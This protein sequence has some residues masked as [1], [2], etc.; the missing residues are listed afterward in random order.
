[1]DTQNA[2]VRYSLVARWS[3]EVLG[4]L[5]QKLRRNK[6]NLE[7]ILTPTKRRRY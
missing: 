7:T 2:I 4:V 3:H 5:E 6:Q 1:M